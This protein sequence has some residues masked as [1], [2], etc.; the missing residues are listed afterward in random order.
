MN[1]AEYD[2]LKARRR[3]YPKRRECGCGC[4]RLV[5][6]TGRK[7]TQRKFAMNACRQR[8]L[9]ARM[10]AADEW[11]ESRRQADEQAASCEHCGAA[12]AAHPKGRRLRFCGGRCQKAAERARTAQA[13][14]TRTTATRR[15]AAKGRKRRQA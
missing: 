12:L 1:Q 3:Y 11:N 10:A 7:G 9:R 4:G 13:A 15:T 5:Y 8:D 6:C 2:A 14:R